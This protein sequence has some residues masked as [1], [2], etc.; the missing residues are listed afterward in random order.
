MITPRRTRLIRVPDLRTFRRVICLLC[1]AP[2]PSTAPESAQ[3]DES[4]AAA[5]SASSEAS[6]AS[7]PGTELRL[8]VVPS[9]GAA[10]TLART[11]ATHGVTG[12]VPILATR[13]ELYD[14]LHQRLLEPPR[15]LT[16]LER[17]A[18]AQAAASEAAKDAADLPFKVRPGL[19]TEILRF[20]DQ[21][22]R[23][24]QSVKRFEE[25]MTQ[26]LGGG[27]LD[28]RGAERL[29][30][31]T[32]FLVQTFRGYEAR[33]AQSGAV[34]EHGLR[35]LL[36]A[37]VSA[38]PLEHVIVT[39]PD[40]IAD[41]AGLFV[42]DF[43][44]LNRLPNLASIDIVS[45]EAALDSGF[46]ER[47]DRWWPDIDQVSA[48]DL[49]TLEPAVRP[50]LVCPLPTAD[51]S[52]LF[53]TR[54]DREEELIAVGRRLAADLPAALD[55]VAIVYK[56][57][58]PYLYLADETLGAA[59][60]PVVV[61]DAL[62]LA[63]EPSVAALDLVLDAIESDFAREP[64]IALVRSPHFTWASAPSRASISAFDRFLSDARFLGGADRLVTQAEA[65]S[66]DVDGETRR[67]RSSNR[68]WLPALETAKAVVVE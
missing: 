41:P 13:D 68:E 25:L 10:T 24:S 63:A 62:P 66:E 18:M 57:P 30:R 4:G 12:R 32:R 15:R 14:A 20:Y 38:T 61:S 27:E 37:D 5:V 39:V 53:Y 36:L 3:S 34:D 17:D 2:S 29:L 28:D 51:A 67:R 48:R 45:T 65:W 44:L 21:L 40:W 47:L 23:Q 43:D 52:P 50:T 59:G 64:L 35:E 49:F 11:L 33:T 42:A 60:I 19:V 8:V 46:H 6:S 31:Q 16:P 7:A 55:R 54:R 9:R 22:R 56:Q 1:N 58:L 26:A